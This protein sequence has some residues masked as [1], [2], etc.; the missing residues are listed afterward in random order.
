[1]SDNDKSQRELF[2]QGLIN[3]FRKQ[4]DDLKEYSKLDIAQFPSIESSSMG[5]FI[6]PDSGFKYGYKLILGAPDFFK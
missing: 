6:D 5:N 3:I 4:M 2:E 1:M